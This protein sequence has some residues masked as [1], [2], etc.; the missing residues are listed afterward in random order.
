MGDNSNPPIFLTAFANTVLLTIA[1]LAS[2][3]VQKDDDVDQ[4]AGRKYL[5]LGSKLLVTDDASALQSLSLP[6][7]SDDDDGGGK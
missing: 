2:D 6:E 7:D 5:I 4:G 1:V 3:C